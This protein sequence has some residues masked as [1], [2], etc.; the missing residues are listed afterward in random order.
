[1]FVRTSTLSIGIGLFRVGLRGRRRGNAWSCY[2]A[3]CKGKADC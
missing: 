1:M 3:V 2:V